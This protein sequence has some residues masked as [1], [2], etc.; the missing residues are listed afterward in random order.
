MGMTFANEHE[1]LAAACRVLSRAATL[2]GTADLN[3]AT[4]VEFLLSFGDEDHPTASQFLG[5]VETLGV[6]KHEGGRMTR[7]IRVPRVRVPKVKAP[8]ARPPRIKVPQT[9]VPRPV[10]V[11]PVPRRPSER[12]I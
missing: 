4:A 2:S 11:R 9:K 3:I 1:W 10:R 8:R 6:K 7:K 5:G 12:I